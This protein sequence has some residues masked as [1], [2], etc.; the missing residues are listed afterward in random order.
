[1]SKVVMAPA[2]LDAWVLPQKLLST[3]STK[4]TNYCMKFCGL[5]CPT[6]KLDDP[7]SSFPL[8]FK[9]MT[10]L[11]IK[12]LNFPFFFHFAVNAWKEEGGWI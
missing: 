1:M 3:S 8:A 4:C 10:I 9:T 6:I 12:A 11:K 5:Q 2:G 7:N